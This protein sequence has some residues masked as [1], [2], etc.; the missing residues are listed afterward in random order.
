MK[1]HIGNWYGGPGVWCSCGEQECGYCGSL[2]IAEVTEETFHDVERLVIPD[3]P[4]WLSQR[5]PV[6]RYCDTHPRGHQSCVDEAARLL[7]AMRGAA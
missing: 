2:L 4:E 6:H 3:D 5:L 7:A 1:C